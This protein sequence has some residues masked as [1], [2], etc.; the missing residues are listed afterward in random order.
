[1]DLFVRLSDLFW[2]IINS[3]TV[4]IGDLHFSLIGAI[5]FGGIIGLAFRI[6][7]YVFDW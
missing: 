2:Y 3:M 7:A 4:D 6:L 5:L 1:M